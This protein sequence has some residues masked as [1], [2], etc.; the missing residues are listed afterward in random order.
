[1]N[2]DNC[3]CITFNIT[4]TNSNIIYLNE[5]GYYK[6]TYQANLVAGAVGDLTVSLMVNNTV[7]YQTIETTAQGDTYSVSLPYVVRV[8]PNSCSNPS[9]CPLPIQLQLTGVAVTDGTSNLIIEKVH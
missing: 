7:V 9:N 4:N 8:C 2:A 6:V 1:L 5:P 3:D